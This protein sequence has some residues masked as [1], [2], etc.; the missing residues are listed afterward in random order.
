M[1]HPRR[2]GCRT[3]RASGQRSHPRSLPYRRKYS[4]YLPSSAT[5]RINQRA[6]AGVAIDLDA[7]TAA[8]NPITRCSAIRSA[9]DC[10]TSPRVCCARSGISDRARRRIWRSLPACCRSSGSKSC[11]GHHRRWPFPCRGWKSI[12]AESPKSTLSTVPSRYAAA[13]VLT[14]VWSTLAA[15][16][17]LPGRNGMARHGRL[18]FVAGKPVLGV[19]V[20]TMIQLSR[21]ALA[22]SGDYERF[23]EFAA[24][25]RYSHILSSKTGWP[26]AG[27]ASVSVAADQCLAAGTCSTIA[28]LKGEAGSRWLADRNVAHAWIDQDG[29]RFA[30]PPFVL[31]D[32]EIRR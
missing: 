5:T 30:T 23:I 22:S 7:E 18:P 9:A 26:V 11:G 8:R 10:S 17:G 20:S 27:L 3:R 1:R 12:S 15:I 4:R 32:Q 29:R 21:G 16:S 28:M 14:R 6:S 13:T 31:G 25:R 24:G 2:C 19:A